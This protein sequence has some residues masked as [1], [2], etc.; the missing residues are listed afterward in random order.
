VRQLLL[1]GYVTGS[2]FAF[3]DPTDDWDESG[4][5]YGKL[6]LRTIRDFGKVLDVSP[7]TYP[8]YPSA[9]S[10][11]RGNMR[12]K[13]T[14]ISLRFPLGYKRMLASMEKNQ[15]CARCKR[16]A[17]LSCVVRGAYA[18]HRECAELHDMEAER[19]QLAVAAEGRTPVAFARLRDA[20]AAI[21]AMKRTRI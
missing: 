8:A 18:M 9:D 1:G 15:V 4:L 14:E 11:A 21:A 6:P 17:G 3:N 10:S 16:H 7:V 12:E 20:K 5:K 19:H 13:A 2:S